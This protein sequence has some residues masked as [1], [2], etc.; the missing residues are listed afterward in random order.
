MC[1]I[2]GSLNRLKRKPESEDDSFQSKMSEYDPNFIW[3]DRD[4]RFDIKP[5]LLECRRGERLIDSLNSVEDSKGNNG[6]R[7]ALQVTNLRLI[8]VSHAK[9]RINLS[10]GL[11]TILA[12]S[13]RKAKSKLRGDTLALCISAKF[14]SKFDFVFTSLVKNSPRLF[15]TVQS[16]LKFVCLARCIERL[17]TI[18]QGLRVVQTV[19]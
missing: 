6:A 15:T 17:L 8:W 3:Q 16:V 2:V 9:D 19:P 12:F 5:N 18:S 14:G 13:I 1:E 7:G 11:N 10:I 4:V